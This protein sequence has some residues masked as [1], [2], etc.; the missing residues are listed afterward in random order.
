MVRLINVCSIGY[1]EFRT[2]EL[3]DRAI[4]LSGTVVMGLPIQ[5][6]HTEAERNRLHPGDGYVRMHVCRAYMLMFH[7]NLNL[8]PG[9]SAPHGGMQ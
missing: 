1:V 2:V 4:A 9:V 8:P 3:V 5:I 6:Q 7:R